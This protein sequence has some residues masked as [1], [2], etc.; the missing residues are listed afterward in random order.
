[1]TLGIR[2]W[3]DGKQKTPGKLGEQQKRRVRHVRDWKTGE[4]GSYIERRKIEGIDEKVK[5]S[6]GADPLDFRTWIASQSL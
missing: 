2:G 3:T 5:I 6:N 1:M 4:E